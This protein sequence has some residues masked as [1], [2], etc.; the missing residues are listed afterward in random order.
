MRAGYNYRCSTY[1][2]DEA[3]QVSWYESAATSALQAGH[4]IATI[5]VFGA[6]VDGRGSTGHTRNSKI[7][8][9]LLQRCLLARV[10]TCWVVAGE[11]S[12]TVGCR[13]YPPLIFILSLY[14]GL[15]VE[16]ILLSRV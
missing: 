15:G 11:V 3:K 5:F 10:V 6:V 4:D 14:D 13:S 8:N 12:T 2:K 9:G 1:M 16:P 7:Q